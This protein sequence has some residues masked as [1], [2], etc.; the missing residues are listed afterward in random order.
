MNTKIRKI[1][2]SGIFI[3]LIM[4]IGYSLA[5]IPNLELVTLLIFLAGYFMGM[6]YGLLIGVVGE[7]LFSVLNPMGSGLLFPPMLIA[8]II[9]MGLTAT[10]GG[11]LGNIIGQH[12]LKKHTILIFAFTGLVVTF[13]YDVFVS[14][15]YPIASGFDVKQTFGIVLSGILFSIIHIVMNTLIFATLLPVIVIR[16]NKSGIFRGIK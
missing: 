6:K 5:Y 10:I 3:A 9:A 4:A 7:F 14:L 8:Q 1:S 12:P 13:F 2:Y 11:L 15:A 16:I